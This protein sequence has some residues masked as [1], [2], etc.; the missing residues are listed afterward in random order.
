VVIEAEY[1]GAA[2]SQGGLKVVDNCT[3]KA[4]EE[5]KKCVCVSV[6]LSVCLFVCLS[7]SFS[8][9]FSVSVSASVSAHVCKSKIITKYLPPSLFSLVVEADE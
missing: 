8:L 7:V 3:A 6:C 5:E 2:S 4:Q 1:R 9:C